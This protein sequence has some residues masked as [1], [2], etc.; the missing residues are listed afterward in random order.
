MSKQKLYPEVNS[1]TNLVEIEKKVLNFWQKEDTFNKSVNQSGA[2]GVSVFY[3]GPP[4]ANGLP[5]YGHIL[6]GFIK[7]VYARYYTMLG[8]KVARRFGW[9]CHGLPAEMGAEKELGFSGKLNITAFGID[10][11]NEHCKK[12]VMKYA[13]QWEQYVTRQARWVDFQN[14]YKT[15][16]KTFME[17]VL[18][19]FKQLYDKG[20]I[21]ESKRVMPYSW[22]CETPLSNFETRMDNAYRQ[23][24]D[25]AVVTAFTLNTP[26]VLNKQVQCSS[27][28]VL[29]WTTTPWTLPSNL[30]LAVGADIEYV[31]VIK[32]GIGYILAKFALP[33]YSKDLGVDVELDEVID[34]SAQQLVGLSYKPLFNYFADHANSFQIF[35]A[36]FVTQGD[37]TGVVHMAPGFGEDDQVVCQEHGIDVVCPVDAQGKFTNQVHDFEGMLVF[38]ANDSVIKKLKENGDWIKTEQYLHN[39][40]H[41]WRTDTPLIYKAISSWYVKVTAFRDRMVELNQQINWIPGH[42]KNGMF[43][44]WIEN[45]RDWSIS[46]NRFWGTPIPVWRSSDP[47]YPRIDVYGSI[48]ELE[49]DFGVKVD[50]LHRPFIDTLTRPNP[51]DPTGKSVMKRVEDVF[52]CWFESGSMPYGQ[53]HYPFENK[54]LFEDNFPADFIVEYSAQTRG[55]FYTLL[56]L[57]TAL[58]DKPP[59]LNCICHGVILDATGQKLSKRLNNYTDPLEIFDQYGSDSLRVAMLSSNVTKGEEL[60]IDKE[61]KLIYDTLRLFIKPIWNAYSF[62][63][64]YA[65]IDGFSISRHSNRQVVEFEAIDLYI[66]SK[67]AHAIERIKNALDKFDT[68][69]AYNAIG[70]FFEVLNNWYI[71]RT[72]NRFWSSDKK[73]HSKI[74]AY[75]TLY[76]CLL[77]MSKAIASLVP[78]LAEEIYLGLTQHLRN[79]NAAFKEQICTSVHLERFP[80]IQNPVQYDGMELMDKVREICSSALFIRNQQNIRTRQPLS[81]MTIVQKHLDDFAHFEE[82]LKEEVNV[83]EIRYENKI[84][85]YA[86][87]NV[88]I[89]FNK[90]GKRLPEKVKDIITCVK[91]DEWKVEEGQLKIAGETLLADEFEY[92]LQLL[93]EAKDG[94]KNIK[95]N[96]S[97]DGL[98]VLDLNIT[99]ELYMEGVMRD[100][101]R[102][103]QHSRKNLNFQIEDRIYLAIMSKD[104]EVESAVSMYKQLIEE[105]TL[106]TI[107]LAGDERISRHSLQSQLVEICE[108][109]LELGL[110]VLSK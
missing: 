73:S 19:V 30:A 71:R 99:H 84:A 17:S 15:M 100:L 21:Y 70:E 79:S 43:G 65:N 89:N 72:R 57:S 110:A 55:W 24:A 23:R 95:V 20:L 3:D 14:S 105:Q 32:N 76:D 60:L 6:T 87:H 42:I 67:L 5:H 86:K 94:A 9:D 83:K 68:Q 8:K 38:D 4:F 82:I 45:A 107:L 27:Y 104:E 25:K 56:V 90:L 48:E 80:S 10:R 101:I 61:G 77:N 58:F 46:R 74:A 34:I 66:Q 22:A 28:K 63:T 2:M 78:V 96:A 11:F 69:A 49:R 92:K 36:D 41:C 93:S 64:I 85:E 91:K 50:D 109:Q 51:D 53:M 37:G 62:F 106:S 16:D 102:A 33:K 44:K 103:V 52:D 39:Y 47:N 88:A 54:E 29:A 31:L 12:S 7:D 1:T 98:V 13:D 75:I 40:P 35:C 97:N 81:C 26:P 59:F 108:R 18:W